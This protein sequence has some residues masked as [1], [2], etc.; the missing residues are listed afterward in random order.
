M[1]VDSDAIYR[2]PKM[3]LLSTDVSHAISLQAINLQSLFNDDPT[4]DDSI[5]DKLTRERYGIRISQ[6]LTSFVLSCGRLA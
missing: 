6:K 5:H 1:S 3:N 2:I 4:D